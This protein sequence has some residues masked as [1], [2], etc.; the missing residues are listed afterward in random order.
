MW[1]RRGWNRLRFSNNSHNKWFIIVGFDTCV[2]DCMRA[3]NRCLCDCCC[4]FFFSF[5]IRQ[6]FCE[7][8][9]DHFKAMT[10][11][12]AIWQNNEKNVLIRK[13]AQFYHAK[14]FVCFALSDKFI[15]RTVDWLGPLTLSIII[16]NLKAYNEIQF[17]WNYQGN[18]NTRNVE[19]ELENVSNI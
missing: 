2:D 4:R 6:H 15:K 5:F 17:H 16:R 19:F 7:L 3:K 9:C 8:W 18:Y 13:M 12:D 10:N 1:N 11:E 14:L